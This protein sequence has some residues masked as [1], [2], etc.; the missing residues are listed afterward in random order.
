MS[1]KR[2]NYLLVLI[3]V[4]APLFLPSNASLPPTNPPIAL[5][6]TDNRPPWYDTPIN[7]T[8]VPVPPMLYTLLPALGGACII[9]FITFCCVCFGTRRFIL[10]CCNRCYCCCPYYVN[11]M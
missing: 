9:L 2:C 7:S 11:A 4:L 8:H 3:T 5:N 10:A 6:Q 1:E